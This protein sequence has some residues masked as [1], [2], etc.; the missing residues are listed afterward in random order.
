ME[1]SSVSLKRRQVLDVDVAAKKLVTWIPKL[2]GIFVFAGVRSS[3]GGGGV[4]QCRLRYIYS[5]SYCVLF[6][7]V[8]FYRSHYTWH[9]F[10]PPLFPFL[11]PFLLALLVTRRPVFIHSPPGHFSKCQLPSP[12][13]SS[14]PL[15]SYHRVHDRL[16]VQL[17]RVLVRKAA[18]DVVTS[19]PTTS[20]G[21]PWLPETLVYTQPS[22]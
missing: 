17:P 20:T 13:S 7:T 3:G 9:P 21:T 10:S 2:V 19:R 11:F 4:V 22:W 5:Y 16:L 15:A 14:Y 1:V 6:I 8:G 18:T 12:H